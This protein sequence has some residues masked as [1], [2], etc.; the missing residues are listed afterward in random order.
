[1]KKLLTLAIIGISLSAFGQASTNLTPQLA[2]VWTNLSAEVQ[3]STLDTFNDYNRAVLRSPEFKGVLTNIVETVEND[4]TNTVTTVTTNHS[5]MTFTRYF[6]TALAHEKV[7]R[8]VQQRND[9]LRAEMYRKV[10]KTAVDAW[11]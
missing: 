11:P 7:G 4:V 6:Q 5:T 3:Q 8:I 10:G 9:E 2:V 1:M